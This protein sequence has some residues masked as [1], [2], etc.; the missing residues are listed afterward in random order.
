[1]KYVAT[2]SDTPGGCQARQCP[3][4]RCQAI[5]SQSRIVRIRTA[6]EGLDT[7]CIPFAVLK[8]DPLRAFET[9]SYDAWQRLFIPLCPD[10]LF[11]LVVWSSVPSA[12]MR[13]VQ[14]ATFTIGIA[15]PGPLQKRWLTTFAIQRQGEFVAWCEEIDMSPMKVMGQA[16]VSEIVLSQANMLRLI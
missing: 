5:Q 4:R 8:E 13:L 16:P 10:Q 15:T 6:I 2:C 14:A 7:A 3:P 12:S 11:F 1:M 9:L